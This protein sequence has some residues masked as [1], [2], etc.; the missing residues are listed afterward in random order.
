MDNFEYFR[1]TRDLKAEQGSLLAAAYGKW[2]TFMHGVDHA[3]REGLNEIIHDAKSELAFA[4]KETR[5][6]SRDE[7]VRTIIREGIY[8]MGF[9][10]DEVDIATVAEQQVSKDREFR[11]KY[12]NSSL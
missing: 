12:R 5:E 8:R 7:W 4:A 1:D 9:P 10:M 2:T 11:I 3:D 6:D